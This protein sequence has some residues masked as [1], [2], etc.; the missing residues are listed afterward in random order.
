MPNVRDLTYFH[1]RDV[2]G[3]TTSWLFGNSLQWEYVSKAQ[4]TRLS[5]LHDAKPQKQ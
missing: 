3:K 1:D 5:F 4:G 2:P